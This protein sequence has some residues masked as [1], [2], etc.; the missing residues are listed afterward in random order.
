MKA[1]ADGQSAKPAEQLFS[2]NN[3]CESGGDGCFCWLFA[4][5]FLPI[6][7]IQAGDTFCL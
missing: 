2:P 7:Y 5:R 1:I 6:Y 3:G 4:A